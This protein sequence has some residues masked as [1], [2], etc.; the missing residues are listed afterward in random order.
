MGRS[1]TERIGW[2]LAAIV[3]AMAAAM[4]VIGGMESQ[5]ADTQ[6]A[7]EEY[8]Q[9]LERE[10]IGRVRDFLER[11]GYRSSGVTLN[12]VVDG[13]GQRSYKVL[14]YH[15]A[16]Y[17]LEEEAQTEVLERIEGLGFQEPDCSF[18]AR[19]LKQ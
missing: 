9:Q 18:T 11:Q 13:D 1:R 15:G 12:R 7:Q 8:Y 4:C 14:V 17:R 10:Y 6:A 16:L 3:L 2:G 5:A 19:L